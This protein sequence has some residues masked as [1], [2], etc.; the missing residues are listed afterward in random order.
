MYSVFS[1]FV[2]LKPTPIIYI[3]RTVL[4]INNRVPNNLHVPKKESLDLV[5]L[6]LIQDENLKLWNPEKHFILSALT[7][8]KKIFYLKDYDSFQY[9]SNEN[10]RNLFNNNKNQFIENAQNFVRQSIDSVYDDQ[11]KLCTLIFTEP[12]PAHELVRENLL[13]ENNNNNNNENNDS[14][15]SCYHDI[16]DDNT[17]D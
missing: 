16:D 7:F 2:Q 10:A 15:K 6:D 8:L 5:S 14:L 1:D 13:G 9:V 17:D 12:K 3:G 4:N 11:H